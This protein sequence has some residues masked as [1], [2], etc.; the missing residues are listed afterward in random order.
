MDVGQQINLD[1]YVSNQN[2]RVEIDGDAIVAKGHT[3]EAKTWGSAVVLVKGEDGA[4]DSA[5]IMVRSDHMTQIKN[6]LSDLTDNYFVQVIHHVTSTSTDASSSTTTMVVDNVSDQVYHTKNYTL[7]ENG[8]TFEGKLMMKNGHGYRYSFK[9][10]T[11]SADGLTVE[12]GMIDFANY[13]EDA[14]FEYTNEDYY[15]DLQNKSRDVIIDGDNATYLPFYLLGYSVGSDFPGIGVTFY[16]LHYAKDE[17]GKETLTFHPW[18]GNDSDGYTSYPYDIIVSKKNSIRLPTVE[19]YIDAGKEPEPMK[20]D[21]MLQAFQALRVSNNFTMTFSGSYVDVVNGGYVK[22]D[23]IIQALARIGFGI[24]AE[25]TVKSNATSY[26]SEV[27]SGY[28]P[29]SQGIM[30]DLAGEIVGY[31]PVKSNGTSRLAEILVSHVDD[32]YVFTS[33][34]YLSDV[35]AVTD[36]PFAISSITD[37]LINGVNVF[38]ADRYM[39]TDFYDFDGLADDGAFLGQLINLIPQYGSDILA[40]WESYG[41]EQVPW[42]KYMDSSYT[43]MGYDT[44]N[45]ELEILIPTIGFWVNNTEAYRYVMDLKFTDIGKTEV[46]NSYL[47]CVDWSQVK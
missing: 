31:T 15:K 13:Y 17:N 23:N 18:K 39:K 4:N 2:Y 24:P 29:N 47:A 14:P 20:R 34:S 33:A 7:V 45:N 12:S 8:A 30:I 42:Y 43:E 35:T 38:A 46:P 9:D 37:D 40:Y 1:D 6:Y 32:S 25:I 19:A 28:R 16:S 44:E 27:Q 41:S 11:L 26:Y 5:E 3:I 36:L 10:A 21:S 22:D